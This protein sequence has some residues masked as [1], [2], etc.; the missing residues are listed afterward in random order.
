MQRPVGRDG[1][2]AFVDQT[3]LDAGSRTGELSRQLFRVVAGH[4]G[5]GRFAAAQRPREADEDLH[6]RVFNGHP[7]QDAD[8][9]VLLL[10]ALEG[11]Q[12]RGQDA[13]GIAQGYP[14]A[15]HAHVDSQL[16]PSRRARSSGRNQDRPEICW[17]TADNASGVLEASEP[18]PWATSSLP[19]P[20]PP[21]IPA[22]VRTRAPAFTPSPLAASLVATSTSG[23]A[24]ATP[25][26]T[27]VA[28]SEPRRERRSRASARR[29]SAEPTGPASWARTRTP[30]TSCACET[31]AA[32][33]AVRCSARSRSISFSAALS[34]A[35]VAWT[36]SVNSAEGT[37]KSSVSSLT[38][39]RSAAPWR[40]A[41]MP[42]RASTRRLPEP[43]DCSPSSVSVPICEVLATWVPPHSSRDQ[44]PSISTTRT[45]LPYFSQNR[46][47]APRFFASASGM[48]LVCTS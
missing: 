27:T 23:R 31:S 41:S 3:Y 24:F 2:Q 22:A 42:T 26:R 18:P 5:G 45:V 38:R 16:N 30:A 17:T 32:A 33:W 15:G 25:V 40:K 14:D 44:A 6:G 7:G 29:S 9:A 46:L 48:M 43:T 47:I 1:G 4:G 12:G 10:V 11:L 28:G 19:P 39:V 13:V 36:R 21:R 20:P 35:S 34:L 8:V 37:R